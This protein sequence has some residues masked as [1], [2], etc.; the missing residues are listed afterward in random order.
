M[1]ETFRYRPGPVSGTV[2][3][4][5]AGD[6]VALTSAFG[7]TVRLRFDEIER[8][9]TWMT[10]TGTNQGI[11]LE[12]P[13]G[14]KLV[15]EY[16][17][18]GMRPDGAAHRSNFADAVVRILDTLQAVRPDL[19]A[20]VTVSAAVK[21]LMLVFGVFLCLF[22]GAFGLG[23]LGLILSGEEGGFYLFWMAVMSGALAFAGARIAIAF[24]PFAR[25]EQ[26]A[27]GRL[28]EIFA[29]WAGSVAAR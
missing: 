13:G 25:P 15:V 19:H 16:A 5:L 20:E 8:V 22:G 14:R 12:A 17:D 2:E 24:N 27:L 9:R 10:R 6:A 4:A 29:G 7:R 26:V 28:A 1:T 11:A 21:W 18:N 23:A 3:I